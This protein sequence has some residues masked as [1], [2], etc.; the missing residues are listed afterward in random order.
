MHPQ[1][2][3]RQLSAD[4]APCPRKTLHKPSFMASAHAK[5]DEFVPPAKR[6]AILQDTGTTKRSAMPPLRVP[7]WALILGALIAAKASHVRRAAPGARIAL[8]APQGCLSA[9]HSAQAPRHLHII[10]GL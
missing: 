10:P 1:G 3:A 9:A 7:A 6:T 2:A 8:A 4:V 5:Q